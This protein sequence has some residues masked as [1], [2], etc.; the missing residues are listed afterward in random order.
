MDELHTRA[1]FEHR[2]SRRVALLR[3]AVEKIN[4]ERKGGRSLRGEGTRGC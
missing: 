1:S 4:G 3:N 2:Y